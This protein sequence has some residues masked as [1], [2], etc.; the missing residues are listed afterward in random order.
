MLQPKA[1]PCGRGISAHKELSKKVEIK[2]C[3]NRIRLFF[4]QYP[5]LTEDLLL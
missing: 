3:V 1:S 4:G 5:F 2:R